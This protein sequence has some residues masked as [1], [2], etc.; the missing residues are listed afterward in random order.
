ML[1]KNSSRRG[2]YLLKTDKA[3]MANSTKSQFLANMSHEI[4]T[5]VGTIVNYAE[6][7]KESNLGEDDRM[8][9]VDVIQRTGVALLYSSMTSSIYLE[10]KLDTLKSTRSRF[11]FP[12][13]LR[14]SN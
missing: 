14:K 11:P 13:V 7:L 2:P 1:L 8:K 6:L 12:N 5:P 3:E 9:F 4:R 10:L